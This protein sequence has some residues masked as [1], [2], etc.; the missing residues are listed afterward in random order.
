MRVVWVTH[1][2]PRWDGDVAGAFLERLATALVERGHALT[3]VAPSDRGQGGVEQRRGVEVHRVRYAPAG[4]ETLAYRGTM[5]EAAGAPGGAAAALAL[6]GALAL[7][8]RRAARAPRADLVHAHWWVPAGVAAWLAGA[9][10]GSRYVVTLHGTDVRL[11]GG[12][13]AR[14]WTARRVLG[15]AAAVTAVSSYLADR[16]ATAAGLPRGR[17]AVEPMPADVERIGRVSAGGGGIVTVA[18]LTEQKRIGLVVDA[19]A[20]LHRRGRPVPLTVIGD[21][22]ERAALERRAVEAGIAGA[23]RF[24]GLVA[25][26][27]IADTIGDA[28]VFAFAA[29]AE[30]YGLAAAEA[31]MLGVPVAALRSGGGVADIVPETGGG[32]LVASDDAAALAAAIEELIADPTS[33]SAAARAGARLRERLAP[34]GRAAAFEAIYREVIDRGGKGEGSG[35]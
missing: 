26:D 27:A 15:G 19:V 16:A 14:R 22:P 7:G 1:A 34:A 13:G 3:V 20:V 32:R 9:F 8:V 24:V 21:G 29:T 6:V 11:L 2:Y 25:P 17:I 12:R 28:D 10:G 18:R 33:R 4:R 35:A 5:V 23:T 30:G 31:L